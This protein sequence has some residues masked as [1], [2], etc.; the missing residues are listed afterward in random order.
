MSIIALTYCELAA[1]A[2][3]FTLN[4]SAFLKSFLISLLLY[5]FP[6]LHQLNALDMHHLHLGFS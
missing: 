6:V 2:A 1:H 4:D 5:F 3:S